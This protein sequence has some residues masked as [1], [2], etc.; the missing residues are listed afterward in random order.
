MAL[1]TGPF[2]RAQG[3]RVGRAR[4]KYPTVR[5]IVIH[6][7]EGARTAGDLGRWFASTTDGSSHVGIGQ[8]GSFARY[9]AYSDTAWT[10]PPINDDSD[11][12]ELCG[13]ARW[14]RAEWLAHEKM[15]DRAA[16]WVASRCQVRKIKPRHLTATQL[17]LGRSGIAGHAD[18]NKAWGKSSHTDPGPNFPWDVLLTKVKVILG[19]TP[20]RATDIPH[21]I[22]PIKPGTKGPQVTFMQKAFGLKQTGVFDAALKKAVVA[23][24]RKRLWLW[25]A[26]GIVGPKTYAAIGKM[27]L[28]K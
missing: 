21:F 7:A 1:P 12:V 25:P 19:A 24:Q 14:S 18:V 17:R 13:F 3:F 23:F 5:F 10:N 4:A 15:L 16:E 28:A 26:D 2:I 9:V 8:D 20:K 6:S 22:A 11:T 27:W